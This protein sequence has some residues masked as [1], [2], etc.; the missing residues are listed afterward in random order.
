[1]SA[2]YHGS[3]DIKHPKH[4]RWHRYMIHTVQSK[5]Y[6]RVQSDSGTP[7]GGPGAQAQAPGGGWSTVEVVLPDCGPPEGGS[8]VGLGLLPPSPPH[9][10]YVMQCLPAPGIRRCRWVGFKTSRLIFMHLL[11]F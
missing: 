4:A 2:F 1:M 7:S 8:I 5:Q 10:K 6:V 11:S 3:S 9:G